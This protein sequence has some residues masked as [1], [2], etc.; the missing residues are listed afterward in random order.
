M[1]VQ[2]NLGINSYQTLRNAIN[3][4]VSSYA[5]AD[6][7]ATTDAGKIS[8]VPLWKWPVGI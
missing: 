1:D 4:E 2:R 3:P 7:T 6:E 5:D 8:I